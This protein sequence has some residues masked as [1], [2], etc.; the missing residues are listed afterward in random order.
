M[1]KLHKKFNGFQ[2]RYRIRHLIAKELRLKDEEYRLW[3]FMVAMCGWDSRHLD[4]YLIVEATLEHISELLNWSKSKTS[5]VVSSLITKGIVVR[6]KT[7]GFLVNLRIERG[8]EE[9]D[10]IV[11]IKMGM[12]VAI[13]EKYFLPMKKEVIPVKRNQ[14]YKDV[15]SLVSSND[16]LVSKD[17]DCTL[18]TDD[19]E[20]I[21]R[22]VN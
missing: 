5:R 7:V 4:S 21:Q 1:N 13:L 12:D 9:E 11:L 20:W 8:S 17:I 22:N 14:G 2:K 19:I 15:P 16:V 10:K 18:S 6:V 3:D